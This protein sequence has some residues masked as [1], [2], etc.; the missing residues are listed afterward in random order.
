MVSYEADYI[1]VGAG[2]A[3]SVLA[4]RLAEDSKNKVILIEA[5]P[6]NTKNEFI[7]QPSRFPFLYDLPEGI[8]PHPSP[9]HWGFITTSQHGKVYSYPR[10]TGLGGSTNHH[11]MVDGRG[12]PTVYDEWA[13]LTDDDCWRY[14]N[15]SPYF[16]KMENFDV[17][18][19]DERVH[20]K[21]G[22]LHIKHGKLEKGFHMDLI[23]IAI[24]EFGMPMRYDFYNDPKNFSG[25]GW[26]DMQIHKDGTRSYAAIDLLLPVYKRSQK[27]GWNNLEILTDTL[28]TKVLFEGK[29]AIGVEAFNAARSYK[30][31]AAHKNDVKPKS[32]VVIKAKKEVILCGGSINTPQILMLSGIG[33]KD[34]LKEYNIPLVKDLP[35]VGSNLQDHTEVA[36]VFHIKNL[37]NKVWRWQASLFS[38]SDSKWKPYADMSSLTE[39]YI[40]LIIDWFSGYDTPNPLHPDLHIHVCTVYLRDFNLNPEKFK[41]PD[42]LKASY[43]DQFLST[44]NPENPMVYHTF[45]IEVMKP[46]ANKGTIRLQSADPTEPPIIDLKLYEADADLTR[47]ALGIQMLRKMMK[48]ANMEQYETEEVLPGSSYQTLDQLKEYIKKYSSFGHHIS[49]TAKMGFFKDPMAVTDAHL[50]VI[51]IKGLRVCDA[52]IFPSLPTYNT[53]RPSYLVGEVLSEMIKSG[54]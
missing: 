32:I 6:D 27:Q 3:G 1:V 51:G 13:K 40:P 48:H 46:T 18:F 50:R 42:P 12:C 10:G 19:A 44:I 4:A 53:S 2:A 47:L 36:H 30:A 39:D 7:N 49:G 11:A 37:P 17:P 8:G 28:V 52:S 43:L 20:G 5:G 35:G 21:K 16:I 14:D 41:D 22:W 29:K 31:D 45:L 9:S 26:T 33:P 34:H 23:Q 38:Q 24:E 54:Q 15:L 25:I